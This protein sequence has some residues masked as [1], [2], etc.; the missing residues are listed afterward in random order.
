MFYAHENIA[1][2]AKRMVPGVE[3]KVHATSGK[4]TGDELI[5]NFDISACLSANTL[6]NIIRLWEDVFIWG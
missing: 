6:V 2:Q 5:R 4:E 3:T 1:G